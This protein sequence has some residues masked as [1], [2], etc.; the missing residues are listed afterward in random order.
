MTKS[1]QPDVYM[2][3]IQAAL[4]LGLIHCSPVIGASADQMAI[5]F[6]LKDIEDASNQRDSTRILRHATED[7]VMISKN[8]DIVAGRTQLVTYLDKMFGMTPALEGLHSRVFL[9]EPIIVHGQTALATGTSE[10]EYAFTDGMKLKITTA[11][12]A[13]LVQLGGEW[14]IARVHFSF[15]LFDNPLLPGTRFFANI[16]LIVGLLTGVAS[17]AALLWYVRFH[18]RMS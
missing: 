1:T 2:I 15:N 3:V 7:I 14:K 17:G 4:M 9:T 11:W 16:A 13:T 10:D 8:G 6:V 5:K 12:S 18:R